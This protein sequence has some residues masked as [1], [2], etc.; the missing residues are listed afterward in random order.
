MLFRSWLLFGRGP[1]ADWPRPRTESQEEQ[2]WDS[3]KLNKKVKGGVAKTYVESI[4]LYNVEIW[5]PGA[6]EKKKLETTHRMIIH[7]ACKRDRRKEASK[8]GYDAGDVAQIEAEYGFR[9]VWDTIS[10]RRVKWAATILEG[11]DSFGFSLLPRG[12][13]SGRREKPKEFDG[14]CFR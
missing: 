13:N 9:P 14:S 10:E 5:A 6:K 12:E 2:V 3:S 4:M 1:Q 11:G 8:K 7:R